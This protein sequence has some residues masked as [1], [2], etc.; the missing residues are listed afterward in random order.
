MDMARLLGGNLKIDDFI[1]AHIKGRRKEIEVTKPLGG[2]GLTL[3]DNG[4]GYSFIKRIKNDSFLE[5]QGFIFVGDHIE[6]ICG[7]CV[8]GWRHFEVCKLLF[9][10]SVGTTFTIRVVEPMS[11]G[12]GKLYI[13]IFLKTALK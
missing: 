11:L 1:F 3:T 4:A 2:L 9:K 6:Q 7:I 5:K 12:V 13:Y 8:V 10:M